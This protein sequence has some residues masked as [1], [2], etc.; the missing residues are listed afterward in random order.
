VV[1]LAFPTFWG[2]QPAGPAQAKVPP[3]WGARD[4]DRRIGVT[5]ES[6]AKNATTAWKPRALGEVNQFE[7]TAQTHELPLGG[8]ITA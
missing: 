8:R 1:G 3:A 5:T 4:G 2:G 7:Q 6:L